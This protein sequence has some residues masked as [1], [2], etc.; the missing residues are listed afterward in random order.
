M[1]WSGEPVGFQP[2][3][4][5]AS[6]PSARR[7]ARRGASIG[8]RNEPFAGDGESTGAARERRYLF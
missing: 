7:G 6:Q 1:G 4:C 8:K 5:S 2:R 3:R